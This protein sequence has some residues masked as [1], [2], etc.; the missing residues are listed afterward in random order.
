VVV[1]AV[2][3]KTTIPLNTRLMEDRAVRQGGVGIH[4]LERLLN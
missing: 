1:P 2:P 4:Y 3:I